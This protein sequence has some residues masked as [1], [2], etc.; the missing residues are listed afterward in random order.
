V[1]SKPIVLGQP[2]A[3]PELNFAVA[4]WPTTLRWAGVRVKVATDRD[5]SPEMIE[6]TPPCGNTPWWS[7]LKDLAGRYVVTDLRD[8]D[9][10]SFE[11]IEDALARIAT[12]LPRSR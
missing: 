11:R 9:A 3:L 4:I 6:V 8:W 10:E 2:F 5:A 7:L 12:K 1:I